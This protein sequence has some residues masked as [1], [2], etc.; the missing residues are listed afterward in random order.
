MKKK[1]R[2]KAAPEVPLVPVNAGDIVIVK[3]SKSAK[4]D[5][6]GGETKYRKLALRVYSLKG[7]E[8]TG[9]DLGALNKSEDYEL[10]DEMLTRVPH[11]QVILNLGPRPEPGSVY[12]CTILLRH[13]SFDDKPYGPVFS[14]IPDLDEASFK[15]LMTGLDK[16]YEQYKGWGLDA[17]FPLRIELHEPKGK[18]DGD[19]TTVNMAKEPMDR[20]RLR[21]KEAQNVNYVQHLVAHEFAHGLMSRL[22]PDSIQALWISEYHKYVIEDTASKKQLDRIV[23]T[24]IK[25]GNTE[26]A[27]AS[28]NE[29]DEAALAAII[30]YVGENH[31]L[32][33]EK[34]NIL[35]SGNLV[36]DAVWPTTDLPVNIMESPIGEYSQKNPSEFFCEAVRWYA[37]GE[38]LPKSIHR[39]VEKSFTAMRGKGFDRNPE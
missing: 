5:D 34:L 31:Y 38:K 33:E 4:N 12:G 35:L 32:D 11:A 37:M 14:Y 2:N 20:V 7:S 9:A 10:D 17:I 25:K 1:D 13:D 15:G 27:Y 16:V 23:R 28:M 24:L 30:T 22:M 39:L 29:K 8:V 3:I 21:P 6:D 19:Y 36:P 18:Y 26:L